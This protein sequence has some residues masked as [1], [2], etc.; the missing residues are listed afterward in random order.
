MTQANLPPELSSLKAAI[1]GYARGF[2]LD[3]FDV[4]FELLEYDELNAVAAGGG[5]PKRYPHWRIGMVYDQLSKGYSFGVQKIYELVINTDPC[6]AYLMTA[7]SYIDQ[8]LVMAHVYAHCDFFKNNVW[9]SKTNRK[10]LDQMANH[11]VRIR[12]Y[13]DRY[14]ED[15]VERFIDTCLSIEDLIDPYAPFV[16]QTKEGA[17]G[18][19]EDELNAQSPPRLRAPRSYMDSF[20]N[21]KE[22]I[23]AQKARVSEQIKQAKGFPAEPERDVMKFILDYGRLESWQADILAMIREEAYYFAPQRVTKI[24]NEGWASY[25][26]SK[27]LTQ[28]ALDGSEV[29]EF[30]DRHAGVM[31]TSP[32]SINPYKLGIE[33]FRHIEERWDKGRFGKDWEDCDDLRVKKAWDKK[34]GLGREK[35]FTVR[36]HHN[37]ITFIDEF[38]TEE[39]CEEQKLY[40][41]GLNP[42]TNKYEIKTR[43]WREVKEEIL[44]GITNG[45]NPVIFVKDGNFRNRGELLLSH[46]HLGRDLDVAYVKATLENISTLWGRPANLETQSEGLRKLYVFDGGEFREE[47]ES[48]KQKPTEKKNSR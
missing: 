16:P 4:I 9:F 47:K 46:R 44:S 20:M 14:G 31:A 38:F 24:M 35:I 7:N 43:D 37:D 23:E 1:E 36:K 39:F 10:M 21:P 33:L 28:K 40:T 32:G 34:L 15:A 2:G 8:K 29:L 26:H 30:A 17:A 3:F 18:A 42:R 19:P 13:I 5:F 22:Y 6:Y 11:A 41:Y 25:W 45:G 48:A 27:I 12:R